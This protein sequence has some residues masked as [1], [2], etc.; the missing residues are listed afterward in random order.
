MTVKIFFIFFL[1]IS[2][3]VCLIFSYNSRTINP[4]KYDEQQIKNEIHNWQ[5]SS[6]NDVSLLREEIIYK[7]KDSINPNSEYTYNLNLKRI[8]KRKYGSCYDRSFLLHKILRL[9]N[10]ETRPV[11]VFFNPHDGY[12]SY[13]DFFSRK[14][15]SHNLLEFK[16]DGKWILLTPNKSDGK[17]S[18]D[19]TIDSYLS[20]N[21]NCP[22]HSIFINHLFSRNF[23]LLSP[24]FLPDLF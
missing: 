17:W 1:F 15:E 2:L 24:K 4:D 18:P 10:I 23:N 12:T 8:L 19:F 16:Y 11:F 14:S 13:L 6:L 7:I 3:Y 9:N 22:D 21:V 20:S 5:I